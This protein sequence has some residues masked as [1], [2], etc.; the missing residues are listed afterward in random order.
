MSGPISLIILGGLTAV[1]VLFLIAS[2]ISS[3]CEQSRSIIRKSLSSIATPVLN[4]NLP[5]LRTSLNELRILNVASLAFVGSNVVDRDVF[6]RI[7][8]GKSQ[9]SLVYECSEPVVQNGLE[10]GSVRSQIDVLGYSVIFMR[11]QLSSII[12]FW[13]L[14]I[15]V[16][17]TANYR[18]LKFINT[19]RQSLEG[20]TLDEIKSN[21][22]NLSSYVSRAL[23]DLP[24]NVGTK[25]I[26]ESL[27]NIVKS[28]SELAETKMRLANAEDKAV[29]ARQVGHDIRSPLSALRILM[30]KSKNLTPPERML[31]QSC[32]SRV[33]QVASDL[34]K[35]AD[36]NQEEQSIDLG[37][38]LFEVIQEKRLQFPQVELVFNN[39]QHRLLTCISKDIFQRVISNLLNNSIE[40][41]SP[42]IIISLSILEDHYAIKIIDSGIGITP[43]ALEKL[44]RGESLTTKKSGNA[45]GLSHARQAL[46]LR[47]GKIEI[48]K[49]IWNGTQIDLFFKRSGMELVSAVDSQNALG[50]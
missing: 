33:D 13:V 45:L 41:H 12:F 34:L 28:L 20:L 44:Q 4:G 31:L 39:S 18:A 3:T 2:S 9:K 43:E 40:A 10:V 16:I 27:A 21:P 50:I 17:I 23:T 42:K 26:C 30:D 36:A 8:V 48:C 15:F 24:R 1:W 29:L 5:A 47:D 11:G 49:S 32:Y 35:S 7:V 38:C 22:V 19:I 6:Q 46:K 14:A 37:H 25:V